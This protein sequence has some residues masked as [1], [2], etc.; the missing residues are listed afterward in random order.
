MGLAWTFIVPARGGKSPATA[1]TTTTIYDDLQ[2][3]AVAWCRDF[4]GYKEEC[5]VFAERLRIDFITYL[6]AKSTDI[7]FHELNE[8]HERVKGEETLLSPRLRVG[9]DGFLYFGLTLFFS[10]G[11]HC[12]DE[13]VRVGVQRSKNQWKLRWN[14]ADLT[15]HPQGNNDAMFQK[16]AAQ[17]FEKFATPFRKTRGQLGFVPVVSSDHLALVP[18]AET[19]IAAEA[20]SAEASNAA[21]AGGKSP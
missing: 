6:G 13:H 17:I 7:E 18:V 4:E 8:Q 10:T 9:D 11:K 2:A 12:V 3:K 21:D 16:A 19:R 20:P 14:R 15:Y 1:M 5:R